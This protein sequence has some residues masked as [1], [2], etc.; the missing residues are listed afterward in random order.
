MDI[1]RVFIN[2]QFKYIDYKSRKRIKDKQTLKRIRKLRIPPAY[3]K[4]RITK[5]IEV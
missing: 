1:R 3:M 4:V 5:K 2:D